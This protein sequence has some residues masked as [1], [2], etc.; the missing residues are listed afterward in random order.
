MFYSEEEAQKKDKEINII[1]TS[2]KRELSL[3]QYNSLSCVRCCLP[4]IGGDYPHGINDKELYTILNNDKKKWRTEFENQYVGPKGIRLKF[5]NIHPLV[6][7]GMVASHYENSFEDIGKEEMEKRFKKRREVFL[8]KYNPKNANKTLESYMN[9]IKK[10]EK[11]SFKKEDIG[12]GLFTLFFGGDNHVDPKHLPECQLLANVGDKKGCLAHP[13]APE[14]QG[15]DGRELVGFF[16][17]TDSC[18]KAS[19]NWTEEFKYLSDSALK[20]FD[21]AIQGMSWYEYSRHSTAVMVAYLRVYDFIFEKMDT[22]GKLENKSLEEL[23]QFTNEVSNKWK[24]SKPSGPYKSENGPIEENWTIPT[25]YASGKIISTKKNIDILI[26]TFEEYHNYNIMCDTYWASKEKKEENKTAYETLRSNIIKQMNYTV[27]STKQGY[28]FIFDKK[29]VI[30]IDLEGNKPKFR[31]EEYE[32]IQRIGYSTY[33]TMTALEL[34]KDEILNNLRHAISG[35]NYNTKTYIDSYTLN[36][37]IKEKLL[38]I[39]LNTNFSKHYDK[40]VPIF[41]EEIE[42]IINNFK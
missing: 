18:T 22:Q 25:H 2:E 38:Y 36:I 28:K 19:C 3:C 33:N 13:L 35:Y 30:H 27:V 17:K 9:A 23:T 29:H 34:G 37:P 14:S 26:G 32:F 8:K 16:K 15:I 39:G 12:S 10:E 20:V 11:Y 21:K 6:S 7:P 42:Q 40:Q 41:R 1:H 4:H 31:E 24:F 5:V